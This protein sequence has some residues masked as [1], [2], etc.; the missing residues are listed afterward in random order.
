MHGL[1]IGLDGGGWL[2]WCG[3]GCSA[4]CLLWP[5]TCPRRINTTGAAVDHHSG[6]KAETRGLSWHPSGPLT[7]GDALEAGR[8]DARRLLRPPPL[9]AS[10][11]YGLLTPRLAVA[12][13]AR[14]LVSGAASV[15]LSRCRGIGQIV[16]IDRRITPLPLLQNGACPFP[17]TQLLSV[18][19]PDRDPKPHRGG[20]C[21]GDYRRR[22]AYRRGRPRAHRR[23]HTPKNQPTPSPGSPCPCAPA[24]FFP[25]ASTQFWI[26]AKGTT[27]RGSRHRCQLARR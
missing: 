20:A 24:P 27:T 4:H 5:C 16:T 11:H 17:C 13:V 14:E 18:L 12:T 6:K 22:R 3:Y 8:A 23:P 7:L 2:T 19:M 26:V 1:Q 21:S 10:H 25:P 15:W 9:A